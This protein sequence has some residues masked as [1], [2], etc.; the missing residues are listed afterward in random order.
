MT[1]IQDPRVVGGSAA[2]PGSYPWM[3]MLTNQYGDFFCGGTII[4]NNIILTAAHCVEG[5]PSK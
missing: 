4:T 1:N 3:A 5:N 2:K